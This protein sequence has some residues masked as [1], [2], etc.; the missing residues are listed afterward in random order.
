[1]SRA[2]AWETTVTDN[3]YE[4]L[5]LAHLLGELHAT[6]GASKEEAMKVPF[7]KLLTDRTQRD[8]QIKGLT[9]LDKLLWGICRAPKGRAMK[10]QRSF[11]HR[12]TRFVHAESDSWENIPALFKR[13]ER[14]TYARNTVMEII[15]VCIEALEQE[16][17]VQ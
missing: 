15:D 9:K 5:R 13:G 2:K 17:L 16:V 10:K 4:D 7:C 11:L 12:T 8:T 3:T 14:R 1:M 6:V